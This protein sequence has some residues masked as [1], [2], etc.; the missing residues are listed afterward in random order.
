MAAACH[1]NLFQEPDPI[2]LFTSPAPYS[3]TLGRDMRE[4]SVIASLINRYFAVF[5]WRVPAPRRLLAQE[6]LDRTTEVHNGIVAPVV[7]HVPAPH[8]RS[9]KSRCDID[10]DDPF[11]G[12][13]RPIVRTSASQIMRL[14]G[15]LGLSR[16]RGLT[17]ILP[18]VN[19]RARRRWRRPAGQTTHC[20]RCLTLAGPPPVAA[21]RQTAAKK[22]A[23]YETATG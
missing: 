11:A 9:I 15:L 6:R 10:H 13:P 12:Q 19:S 5:R 18:V 20:R 4:R 16:S 21:D 7:D 8:S 1:G 23:R 2:L 17:V 22:P 14:A 3:E